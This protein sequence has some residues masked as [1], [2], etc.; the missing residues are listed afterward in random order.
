MVSDGQSHHDC[1][2]PVLARLCQYNSCYSHMMFGDLQ[3]FSPNITQ[4]C[5]VLI[6]IQGC[7][8]Y[9]YMYATPCFTHLPPVVGYL[10]LGIFPICPWS[11]L[12]RYIPPWCAPQELCYHRVLPSWVT[13]INNTN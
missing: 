7:T 12:E 11:V 13:E 2:A 6:P 9:T 3:H 1:D 5:L 10:I 8:V 4:R